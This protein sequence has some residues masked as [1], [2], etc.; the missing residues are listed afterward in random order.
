LG[1][2]DLTIEEIKGAIR[3]LTVNSELYPV[4]CGSAFKN[5][6]VQPMLDAVID[7]LPSPLDV[8]AVKGR[9]PATEDEEALRK[10][11]TD[12]P[13]AAL[14]FK[15]AVHPFF[16]KLT[17]VRVYSGKVESGAQV[18]NATKGKKERLGKLFQ[19]HAN[20]EN[21]VES[22]SAGHIYAVIGLKDTTTRG[23]PR[24]PNPQIGPQSR[25]LPDAGNPEG[26]EPNTKNDK[27][28]GVT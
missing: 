28:A 14:A 4:L 12:E 5:K 18:V 22:A 26:G 20:K 2:E 10:P 27:S 11:W 19:M 6:G 16:G 15:I 8:A 13:L 9:V 7:Y 24:E 25:N 1:G 17:Y 23:T 21:P 3:K